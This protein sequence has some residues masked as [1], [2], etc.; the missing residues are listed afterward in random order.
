M[1]PEPR[2]SAPVVELGSGVE[3]ELVLGEAVVFFCFWT[4]GVG[5]GVLDWACWGRAFGLGVAAWMGA[6]P[7]R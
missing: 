4:G 1:F 3:G 5:T 6:R 7:G 2:E